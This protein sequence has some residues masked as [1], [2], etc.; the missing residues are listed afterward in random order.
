MPVATNIAAKTA[1][2]RSALFTVPFVM[3]LNYIK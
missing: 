3:L 1:N 2:E